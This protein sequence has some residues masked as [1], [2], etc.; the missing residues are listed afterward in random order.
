[1]GKKK[2]RAE[3]G[4]GESLVMLSCPPPDGFAPREAAGTWLRSSW[5][6]QPTDMGLWWSDPSS[7][8]GAGRGFLV[9]PFSNLSTWFRQDQGASTLTSKSSALGNEDLIQ[10]C[11]LLCLSHHPTHPHAFGFPLVEDVREGGCPCCALAVEVLA[12][13]YRQGWTEGKPPPWEI[14]V[15]KSAC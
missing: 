12:Q 14:T 5:L 6:Q 10:A 3:E 7:S 8:P 13:Q 15:Q 1:M 11:L 2:H 4:Y 9:L